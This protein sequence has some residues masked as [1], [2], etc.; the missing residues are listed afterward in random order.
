[1]SAEP[2]EAPSPASRCWL[3]AA[4]GY[5]HMVSGN[6]NFTANSTARFMAIIVHFRNF[7]YPCNAKLIYKFQYHHR[8][9]NFANLDYSPISKALNYL[10]RFSNLIIMLILHAFH[11]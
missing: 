2:S 8:A 7:I 3:P 1:M 4:L 5:T 11:A 6:L 10:F 9:H